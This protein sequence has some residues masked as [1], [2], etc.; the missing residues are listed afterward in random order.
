MRVRAAWTVWLAAWSWS[1]RAEDAGPPAAA[2]EE[3]KVTA[4]VGPFPSRV[5]VSVGEAL[6]L[7][8]LPE[9]EYQKASIT[10]VSSFAEEGVRRGTAAASADQAGVA[11]NVDQR[12]FLLTAEVDPKAKTTPRIPK[13][14]VAALLD[15]VT[16]D[17][18]PHPGV[19]RRLVLTLTKADGVEEAISVDLELKVSERPAFAIRDVAFATPVALGGGVDPSRLPLALAGEKVVSIEVVSTASA[20]GD[21]IAAPDNCKPTPGG[22]RCAFATP[23]PL[24]KALAELSAVTVT[25]PGSDVQMKTVAD[26]SAR[27]WRVRANFEGNRD[28]GYELATLTVTPT[29]PALGPGVVDVSVQREVGWKH[30]QNR[31]MAQ[32]VVRS[33][34]VRASTYVTAALRTEDGSTVTLPPQDSVDLSTF[35]IRVGLSREPIADVAKATDCVDAASCAEGGV[36]WS[37]PTNALALSQG[38][39]GGGSEE[40]KR[41]KQHRAGLRRGPRVPFAMAWDLLAAAPAEGE[42]PADPAAEGMKT[43][44]AHVQLLTGDGSNRAFIVANRP[45]RLLVDTD[46]VHSFALV[47]H[48][49]ATTVAVVQCRDILG[50]NGDDDGGDPTVRRCQDVPD[51]LTFSDSLS[52]IPVGLHYRWAP[53][54]QR[55]WLGFGGSVSFGALGES[56]LFTTNDT[57]ESDAGLTAPISFIAGLD[58]E[59]DFT[60]TDLGDSR[61]GFI[62]GGGVTLLNARDG[63]VWRPHFGLSMT[64]PIATWSKRTETE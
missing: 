54:Y 25:L 57:T 27:T 34:E 11:V 61:L 40:T 49:A 16:V 55:H 37:I 43:L 63:R 23:I 8:A 32:K 2:P 47:N 9:K 5:V 19:D 30:W 31:R 10:L 6:K 13:A 53:F 39:F 58:F 50:D 26:Y 20:P 24:D 28:T 36:Y 51:R 33:E 48:P 64:V 52:T 38:E 3:A 46:P 59:P 44:Y 29:M 17:L 18:L 45:V 15:D 60:D 21:T 62:L 14:T 56:G 35:R 41:R 42:E 12:G 7:S 1:A 22:T 4:E